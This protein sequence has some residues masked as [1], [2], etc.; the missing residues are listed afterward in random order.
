MIV[1]WRERL[2]RLIN[3]NKK[4]FAY[5]FVS[6]ETIEERIAELQ[7]S[8]RKLADAIVAGSE[9]FLRDLTKDQ[10]DFLFR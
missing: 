3:Q 1:S 9:S 8:K 10:L 5:R 4:V 6:E 7:E 2:L